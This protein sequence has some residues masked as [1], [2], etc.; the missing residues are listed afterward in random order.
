[1][2]GTV[3]TDSNVVGNSLKFH[4]VHVYVDSLDTIASYKNLEA[5][6]NNFSKSGAWTA[7]QRYR[8]NVAASRDLVVQLLSG[9][10]FRVV[11]SYEG[12]KTRN[13]M[14]Q[15]SDGQEGTRFVFTAPKAAGGLA[16]V[17]SASV[18][19][20]S[21]E[22]DGTGE[23]YEHF[24]LSELRRVLDSQ[25]LGKDAAPNRQSF[26]VLAFEVNSGESM[27]RVHAA[28]NAHH[29]RLVK[30]HRVYRDG[31]QLLEVFAYYRGDVKVSEPD[32]GTVIR[33]VLFGEKTESAARPTLLPGFASVQAIF[34][35]SSIPVYSDHWVS[36]VV[37]RTGF[38]STLEDTLGFTPKVDFNAGVVAAGEAQIESTVTGNASAL[39]TE[40]AKTAL[41]A[42]GQI[43]L[44]TNNALSEVG[45]VSMFLRE[46]G[47]G[48]Q[49]IANRCD[50]IVELI[51]RI[52]AN[53]KVTGSAFTFLNIPRSYYGRLLASH[54][55]EGAKVS[56]AASVDLLRALESAGVID[57]GGICRLDVDEKAVRAAVATIAN[58][59]TRAE[60]DGQFR[61]IVAV[62][63]RSRY[64]NLYALL[65]ERFTEKKYLDLVTNKILVDVQGR[66]VLFQIF[67]G[68][69]LQR[70]AGQ[71]APFVEFIQRVCDVS[72]TTL[73][74]GC[75]GF[76]I[77]NFLT[78]FLSIEVSKAMAA[79]RAAVAT[80]DTGVAA[81]EEKRIAL[82]THQMDVS[83]PVLTAISDA[84]TA[85]ADARRDAAKAGGPARR[86]LLERAE[87]FRK[88]KE[89]GNLR[90]MEISASCMK[91]MKAIRESA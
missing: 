69:V 23:H 21:K 27:K 4:H 71:E 62:V 70:V 76:G 51:A 55:E 29:P 91:R 78:L 3:V 74:P 84:M 32:R 39:E 86:D 11:A 67:T 56:S 44:P 75:G 81:L 14:V 60:I 68:N 38:L 36:N 61:E 47:Q 31:T 2:S 34:D 77:R 43:Y 41:R 19:A 37:S 7:K 6:L 9:P 79:K 72:A 66:D 53:E 25:A 83:N 90:L 18:S 80:G 88:E 1:M 87:R 48:V 33:F 40:D 24:A 28:Y 42:R 8:P 63:K 30:G 59:S 52:N 89:A 64:V 35:K 15:S 12:A 13:I 58:A 73:R 26:A 54:V 16:V 10:G 45:H 57:V 85:E 22:E 65:G 82:F 46:I 50:D 49:H 20:A 5:D 17:R